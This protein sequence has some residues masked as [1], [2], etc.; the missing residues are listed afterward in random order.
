MS[1][2]NN[3]KEAE[4]KDMILTDSSFFIMVNEPTITRRNVLEASKA[5]LLAIKG[6]YQINEIKAK[7][8]EKL[9][10]LRSQVREI[11]LLLQK[12]EEFMPKYSKVEANKRFP[13]LFEEPKHDVKKQVSGKKPVITSAQSLPP[14]IQKKL[15]EAERLAQSMQD[16]E[17]KLKT[18]PEKRPERRVVSEKKVESVKEEKPEPKK[19]EAPKDSQRLDDPRLSME[20]MSFTLGKTLEGIQKKLKDL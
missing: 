15:S 12:A 3:S 10:L 2:N 9:E 13:H 17:E 7:K 8:Q 4:R 11:R 16:V 1:K 6:I 20:D 18:L 19:E 5:A 14:E